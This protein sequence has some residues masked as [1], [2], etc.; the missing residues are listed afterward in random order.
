MRDPADAA[1]FAAARKVGIGS[2]RELREV[3][4]RPQT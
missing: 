1:R 2:R 4:S 3:L